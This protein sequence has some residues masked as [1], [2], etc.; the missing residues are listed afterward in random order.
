MPSNCPT[1]GAPLINEYRQNASGGETLL[2]HCF[3]STNHKINWTSHCNNHEMV[4]VLEITLDHPITASW[5]F[6]FESLWISKGSDW[7]TGYPVRMTVPFFIPEL[8]DYNK[9]VKKLKTYMVFS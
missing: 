7:K 2:K 8:K 9:L 4:A 1:C 3:Y 5:S 6:L